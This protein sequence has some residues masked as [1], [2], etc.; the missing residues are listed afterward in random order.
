MDNNFL[1]VV[2]EIAGKLIGKDLRLSVAE[3]CTGGLISDSITN[4]PGSSRFFE[5]SVVCYSFHAKSSVLGISGSLL[6]KYGM[7]SEET[8]VAM[9]K[10]VCDLGGTAV[11]LSVTGVAGP[12][13]MEEREAGLVYMSASCRGHVESQGMKFNGGREEIKRQASLEALKFLN[14]VLGIWL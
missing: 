12:E 7:V 14:R 1:T 13:S 10:S 2:E 3:S 9:A 6:E 8:A 4:L 5:M 11:S